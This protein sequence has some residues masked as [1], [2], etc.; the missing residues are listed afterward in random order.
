MTTST[1]SSVWRLSRRTWLRA[2]AGLAATP[3][4]W[5]EALAARARPGR[6]CILL[7]MDG[8][9]SQID[10]FD[11]KRHKNGGPFR[12]VATSVPGIRISEHLPRLARSMK[13]LALIRSMA[14]K[15]GDHRR[16]SY[17]LS[18]GY[19]PQEPLVHPVLGAL[20]AKE[21]GRPDTDLPAY[22][23]LGETGFPPASGFLGARYA[24]L[25]L[26]AG[27]SGEDG[28]KVPHLALP[29]GVTP[30]QA[31]ARLA[32]LEEMERVFVAGRPDETATGHQSAFARAA[33]LMRGAAAKA[34]DLDAE[35]AA[36]RDAYGRSP[37][38]QGC[39]LARRLVER[40]VRF[41]QVALPGW[42]THERNFEVVRRLSGVLD[43]WATLLADLRQ[44]GLLDT[45]LIVWM[46]E[47]GRTPRINPDGGRDHH[48][49]A[50]S[51]VLGGG[52]IK[53][54]QVVG[55]TSPDG[56]AVEERPVSVP[57]L[58]ATVCL[59][60]GIDP[61]KENDAGLGRPIRL[62]SKLARPIREVLA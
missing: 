47:F 25:L 35:P 46:G 12:E 3:L 20:V 29:R 26:G 28:F 4:G 52:G 23:S 15:E 13:D 36:L 10:T 59:A 11:L 58:L 48:P 7:W 31:D 8:G 39:L 62:V 61:S 34:F 14:T 32:L 38:G 51:V 22:V 44:R 53:G 19:L 18:T 41:V 24:P 21:L 54:G 17:Y 9:P 49:A 6:S 55:K 5:L 57:D 2:A 1:R 40:G 56:S 50:W 43:A 30:A 33:R 16:A 45:T 27:S 42:D 60:L 37:F